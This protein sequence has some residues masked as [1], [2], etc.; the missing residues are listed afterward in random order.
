MKV[1]VAHNRYRSDAPSGENMMVDAE[2]RLLA[3]HG[4][5]IIPMIEESD[6][7]PTGLRGAVVAAPGAIYSRQGVERF[8]SLLREHRPD[9]VHLHNVFPLISPWVVRVANQEQVPVVQ[10]VHNYRHSCVNGLH[11]REG[12]VCTDCLSTRTNWPAVRHGCYRGSR[13]Q[14][15]PMVLSQDLHHRTWANGVARFI[16]LTPFMAEMLEK[17][18]I[19]PEHVVVRPTWVPDPGEP[20][21]GGASEALFVGRLDENKGIRL[22]L[23]AWQATNGT[24]IANLHIVGLGTLQPLV[25]AAAR[26]DPS[27]GYHGPLAKDDVSAL[28]RKCGVV[29][30]P[31]TGFEGYP[32]VIAEAFAHGRPVITLRGGSSATTGTGCT[33]WTTAPT[34]E[35][36][37]MTIDSISELEL[38]AKGQEARTY[39]N[40]H[41]SPDAAVASLSAVYE[42]LRTSPPASER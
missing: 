33:G 29:I 12:H 3:G 8:R 7:I 36:L 19:P 15:L 28:M 10:T 14:S 26:R 41:N 42:S 17:S 11:F 6:S 25:E 22:L 5:D 30:V 34:P 21:P 9:V 23:D 31:S 2:I 27:I 37:A 24:A 16:A 20:M 13:L 4:V 32:L 18:G 35:S 1:L 38:V 40:R 39:Y